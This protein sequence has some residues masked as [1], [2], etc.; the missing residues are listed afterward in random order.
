[1]GHRLSTIRNADIIGVVY[2]GKIV[3]KGS[4]EE[5]ITLE[6]GFYRKFGARQFGIVGM[7]EDDKEEGGDGGRAAL[8]GPFNATEAVRRVARMRGEDGDTVEALQQ[9]SSADSQA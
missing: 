5:L 2:Q 9:L 8:V 4:H 3:E 7:D 1:M 6:D